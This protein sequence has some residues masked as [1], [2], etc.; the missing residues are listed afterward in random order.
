MLSFP[1]SPHI[2]YIL[3]GDRAENNE[4]RIINRVYL[5]MLL[6]HTSIFN[7]LQTKITKKLCLNFIFKFRESKKY[8]LNII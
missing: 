3:C 7:E 2:K 4:N 6:K 1:F 5:R 8:L